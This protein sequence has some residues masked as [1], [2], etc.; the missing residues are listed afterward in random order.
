MQLHINR[1]SL[2]RFTFLLLGLNW[3]GA[4]K[5]FAQIPMPGTLNAAEDIFVHTDKNEYIA[6][7]I[8]WF[9]PHLIDSNHKSPAHR[10]NI[11]YTELLNDKGFAVLQ[12]KTSLKEAAASG[13]F[14]LPTDLAGG[15]YTL[16]AYTSDTKNAD[17]QW[18]FKKRITIIN[19]LTEP[20]ERRPEKPA[21]LV[22]FFPEGGTLVQNTTT[23]LGVQALDPVTLK[24]M[25]VKGWILENGKDTVARFSTPKYGLGQFHFTA[26]A[27][28]TYTATISANGIIRAGINLPPAQ[29]AGF[30]LNLTETAEAYR[31][32]IQSSDRTGEKLYLVIHN[33][34]TNQLVKTIQADRPEQNVTVDKSILGKGVFY[35]TLLDQSFRPLCERLA[36]IPSTPGK[37]ELAVSSKRPIYGTREKATV[38][39]NNAGIIAPIDASLSI[40]RETGNDYQEPMWLYFS[41]TRHLQ[42]TVE[43]PEFYFTAQAASGHYIDNLML[44][45][46]WRQFNDLSK[47]KPVALSEPDG[48]IVSATVKNN[49]TKVPVAGAACLLTV[50]SI[51]YGLYFG[52]SD[53]SGTVRFN[54]NG[55]YGPGDIFITP[56]P[57]SMGVPTNYMVEVNSPFADSSTLRSFTQPHLYLGEADSTALLQRSIN[58]QAAHIYNK[59]QFSRFSRPLVTDTLPF[60]GKPEFKYLLDDYKRFSTLEEV[61]REY[62]TPINVQSKG[63]KLYMSIYDEKYQT[64]YSDAFLVL[65]DGVPLFDYNKIFSY[66][67]YKVKKL[68]V[69]PRRY[70][71]G[72]IAFSGIASFETYNAG[73]DGFELNPEA[74]AID[75]EGLQIQREFYTPDYSQHQG[76]MRRPDYR[77]TLLW[78]PS[79]LLPKSQTSIIDCFTSDVPGKYKVV[80]QGLSAEGVPYYGENTFEIKSKL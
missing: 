74:V 35:F 56:V 62:V 75:Y 63:G 65:L 44:T 60:Y 73:F 41:L 37:H 1:Q 43:H 69:V 45:H 7:E 10:N 66:D 12:S 31:A 54:V 26:G 61:L 28:K 24:G 20:V 27:G 23:T 34:K 33:G 57:I 50:P 68:D 49:W 77:T 58:M 76:D 72:P 22:H 38:E 30:T 8:L 78:A 9:R 14:Y 79:L 2:I 47:A 13:S 5:S 71:F 55:Y 36:F 3:L 39:V 59:D 80:L 32:K 40:F 19:T 48:H 17:K 64:V 25:E 15:V 46:G 42:G 53:S 51:P 21:V 11:I 70:I 67:P 18:F 4:V 16:T 29:P 52:T 6:G